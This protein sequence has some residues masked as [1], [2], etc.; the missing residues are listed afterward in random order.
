[1]SK[2]RFTKN[3]LKR[4]KD[5]LKRFKRY[6]P[7][8]VLK[9]QQLQLEKIKIQKR[10]YDFKVEIANY[11]EDI[12]KW[13]DVFNEN[14][15]IEKLVKLE[16]IHTILG[17]IAGADIPIF[18]KLDFQETEYNLLDTPLW[19]DY[20]IGS[21]KK[22][23]TLEANKLILEKQIEIIR[24]ELRITTQRVNLFEKIKI[25]EAQEN[26]RKIQIYLGDMQTASVVIG[27][28]AKEKIEK[29]IK[30]LVNV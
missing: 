14:I 26:I 18:D 12:Y 11:S 7:T 25:P 20:G 9:K 4:Q 8:L 2:I 1:M 17:N 28:I 6:L 19:I 30:S 22:M 21:L 16:K 29:K 5:N 24:E 23:I 27:K 13:V 3:E 15:N 10:L